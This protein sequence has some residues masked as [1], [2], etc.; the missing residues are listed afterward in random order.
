MQCFIKLKDYFMLMKRNDVIIYKK[1]S[2]F[3]PIYVHKQSVEDK[4]TVHDDSS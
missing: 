3:I 2:R 1:D 4:S